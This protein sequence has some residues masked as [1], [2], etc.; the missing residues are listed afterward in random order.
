MTSPSHNLTI[1]VVA[2]VRANS[3]VNGPTIDP[4]Q[5]VKEQVR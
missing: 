3:S 4:M 2:E 5:T 1:D